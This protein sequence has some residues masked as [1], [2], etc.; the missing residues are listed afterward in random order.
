MKR[1]VR[2]SLITLGGLVGLALAAAGAL[3]AMSARKLTVK[4]TVPSERELAI[5]TD[6]G[7]IARGAHLITT[8]ACGQCHGEDLGGKVFADAGPFA[9]LAGPNLTTGRGGR[10]PPRGDAEWER[11]IRHGVRREGTALV[12]MP[13]EVFHAIT[14]DDMASMVAYLKQ[15]PPVDREVPP[16]TVR[17]VG[18]LVLG[19]GQFRTAADM[20]PRT[21]HVASVD[22]TPGVDYGRY[23]V[24]VSGCSMCHGESYSGG[25]AFDTA[26]KPPSNLTPTGIGHYADED[27]KQT[28]R[29]GVRPHGGGPLSEEMPW[30]YYG[31]MSDGELQSIWLYLKTLPPKHFGEP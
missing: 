7:S 20:A 24:S 30:K 12:V 5:P 14:D 16:T 27:F 28:L 11:A 10:N 23:L 18:R 13:S 29:T 31:K 15:M 22:T 25:P 8:R 19:A 26:G 4:R 3:Y 17:I 2:W 21:A 9:L 6:S 1:V